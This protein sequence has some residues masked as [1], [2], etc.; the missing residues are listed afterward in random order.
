MKSKFLLLACAMIAQFGSSRALTISSPPTFTP[1]SGA[2]LSGTLDLETDIPT[3]VRVSISDGISTWRRNFFDYSTVHSIPL[4]GFKFSRTNQITVTVL[5]HSHNEA[6]YPSPLEFISPSPP[7]NFP[8]I[9]L[10]SSKSDLMEP[11]YTLFRNV[12]ISPPQGELI[13]VDQKGEVVWYSPAIA[14]SE[15]RQLE[16]GNLFTPLADSFVEL[17]LFGDTVRSFSTADGLPADV[18]DAFVTDHD[19]I[20]YLND[21]VQSVD[22]Y[23]T[24][25]TDPNAPRET[26][27]ILYTRVVEVSTTDAVLLNNWSLLDMLDPYRLTYLSLTPLAQAFDTHH[28]NAVTQDPRDNSIVV[29]LRNQNAVVAFHPETGKL[30]WILGPH[31]NWGPQFAPYLLNPVGEPFQW[32]YAQHAPKITSRGTLLIYDDGNF[33]ATPFDPPVPDSQNYS[34]AVEYKIDE[35]K[36]E[37]SQLWEYGA[38]IPEPL[39]TGSVGSAFDLPRTG[40]VLISFGNV[41]WISH[42][43]PSEVATNASMARIKEVTYG[44][45]S[46]V[47]FDLSDFFELPGKLCLSGVP[48]RGFLRAPGAARDRSRCEG[49]KW[50]HAC[51]ILSRP[52]PHL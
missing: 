23:P 43:K 37:I 19:S 44:D 2:P 47:V 29:S 40:N 50:S 28:P 48:H 10:V 8:V 45:N 49:R 39:Y 17:N 1:A 41:S 22:N 26:S 38:N 25:A 52:V 15:I 46:E 11:G 33:R 16:N 13:I 21:S 30:K 42:Q 35:S 20:L 9:T 3:R 31:E 6:T 18:H 7:D 36:M 34:R 14:G 24:S 51:A 12:N 27:D 32:S 4:H 5:D